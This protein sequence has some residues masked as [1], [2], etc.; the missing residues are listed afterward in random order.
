[1]LGDSST[2]RGPSLAQ[3]WDDWGP[4]YGQ[5]YMAFLGVDSSTCEMDDSA[6]VGGRL[7]RQDRSVPRL[8]LVRDRSGF[9]TVTP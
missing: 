6:D 9:P 4:F 3:A 7:G 1:M 8:L 2:G 5:T